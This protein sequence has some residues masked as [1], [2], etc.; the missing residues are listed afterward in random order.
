[1]IGYRIT[2][3]A[4]SE[5]IRGEK[6]FQN[7]VKYHACHALPQRRQVRQRMLMGK[8]YWQRQEFVDKAAYKCVV[9]PIIALCLLFVIVLTHG[10]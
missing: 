6:I 7:H 8:R 3:K 2:A 1:M 4:S 9:V 10:L 5:G